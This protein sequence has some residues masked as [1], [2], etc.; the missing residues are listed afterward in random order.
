M[1][2]NSKTQTVTTL[3]NKKCETTKKLKC[4]KTE[5]VT[6]LIKSKCDKTETIANVTK[7]KNWKLWQNSICDKI[8]KKFKL[9]QYTKKN[10]SVI[11][12]EKTTKFSFFWCDNIQDPNWNKTS[13][14]KLWY[15]HKK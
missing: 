2:R 14:I 3:K 13:N 1:W 6:K 10:S 4:D 7:L 9:W 15:K 8:K 5:I 12:N 11:K